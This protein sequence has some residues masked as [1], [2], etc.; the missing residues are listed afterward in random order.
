MQ[1]VCGSLLGVI[2]CLFLVLGVCLDRHTGKGAASG[3][4]GMAL[5]TVLAAVR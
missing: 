4:E 5:L 2:F 3:M 1:Y